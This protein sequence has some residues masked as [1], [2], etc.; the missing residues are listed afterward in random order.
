[1]DVITHHVLSFWNGVEL[2][3]NFR[4][5]STSA[6]RLPLEIL[7]VVMTAGLA[8][9][10]ATTIE[11]NLAALSLKKPPISNDT[12]LEGVNNATGSE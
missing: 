9:S 5:I 2:M 6:A 7:L 1:M 11:H 3:L 8:A 12:S 4:T 10:H